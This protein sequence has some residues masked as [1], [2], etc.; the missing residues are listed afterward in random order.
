M[1]Q[2]GTL[3]SYALVGE[4]TANLNSTTVS[5]NNTVFSNTNVK[6]G[7]AIRIANVAYRIESINTSAN[8]LTLD[9]VYTSAN[10]TTTSAT[11]QQS[12]KEL[13]TY[14]VAV[15]NAG[16]HVANV[17]NKRTTFG[18]DA[19]EIAVT[20]NKNKGMSHTGWTHY[21]TYTDAYGTTR[22]KAETL[23]AMSKNFNESGA[24][25]LLTDANDDSTVADYQLYFLTA[26]VNASN[27]AGGIISYTIAPRSR[28]DGATI[29]TQWFG[30]NSTAAAN[31]VAISNGGIYSGATS[32][33]L[34]ISNV[35]ALPYVT[36]TYYIRATISSVTGGAVSN[37]ATVTAKVS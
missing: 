21:H 32:N 35:S 7:Y 37:S 6:A 3:D 28:P 33:T 29:T 36:D 25:T 1:S 34:T 8:T 2:W 16:V 15:S 12:P 26:P 10:I 13:T 27:V 4:V 11:I 14:G 20:S 22:H 18:V 31:F 24:G 30:S 19:V 17:S 23:V 9:K 5:A